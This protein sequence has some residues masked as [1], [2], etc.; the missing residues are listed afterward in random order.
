MNS[1]ATRLGGGSSQDSALSW[2]SEL[3]ASLA[4]TKDVQFSTL[5]YDA[6]RGEIRVDVNM[7]DFQSF[8]VLRSQLAERFS[9][10]QGPLD[11]DG[12]RVTGSYTLRSKP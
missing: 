11:R 7:K 6:Q 8:E 1:E 5:R 4:N 2:L 12:D 3:A 9:V 10:S